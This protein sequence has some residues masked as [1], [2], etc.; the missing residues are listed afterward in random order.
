MKP[1]PSPLKII[2]F[3]FVRMDYEFVP[4]EEESK[5]NLFEQYDLDI[6][7]KIFK[8]SILQIVMTA[9]INCIKRPLPGYRIS[10]EVAV[11]FKLDESSLMTETEKQSVEGFSSVYMALNCMRTLVSGFTANAP[12]GRYILPSIDLNDLIKR[13]RKG[14]HAESKQMSTRKTKQAV[15]KKRK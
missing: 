8:N 12:L 9:Q 13:K 15:K 5:S 4:Y 11:L 2:D 1:S 10:A 3:A 14:V 6:D 7:F